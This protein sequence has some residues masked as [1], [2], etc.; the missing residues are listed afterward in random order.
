MSMKEKKTVKSHLKT[1][2]QSEK[3]LLNFWN[4]VSISPTF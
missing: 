2:T 3:K 1:I 4:Q